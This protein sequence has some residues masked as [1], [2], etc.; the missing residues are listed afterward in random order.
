MHARQAGPQLKQGWNKSRSTP[1]S[2]HWDAGIVGDST[3]VS[4]HWDAEIMGVPFHT[5][6]PPLGPLDHGRAAAAP[7]SSPVPLPPAP[8]LLPCLLNAGPCIHPSGRPATFRRAA[9]RS[10]R[11]C[12]HPPTGKRLQQGG[13]THSTPP[14]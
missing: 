11:R 3:L 5:H 1:V 8:T 14:R 7:N 2:N 10:W 12:G 4:H 13:C 9:G 6:L